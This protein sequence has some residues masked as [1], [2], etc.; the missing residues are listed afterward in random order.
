ME[1]AYVIWILIGSDKREIQECSASS[2]NEIF[3]SR[4]S[5]PT[6]FSLV[7]DTFIALVAPMVNEQHPTLYRGYKFEE[8]LRCFRIQ[9]L[10][11]L[12]DNF[13]IK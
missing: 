6:F 1:I 11:N 5:I 12:L 3:H 9:G 2:G 7:V 13:K 10:K 8:F 4:I